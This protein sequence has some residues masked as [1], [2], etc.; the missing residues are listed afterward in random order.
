MKKNLLTVMIALVSFSAIAQNKEMAPALEPVN[1]TQLEGTW[2][3][4]Y[5][6]SQA[7][8]TFSNDGSY[9]I[10]SEA[11]SQMNMSGSY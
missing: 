1:N 8:V 10:W 11:F 4:L 9:A 6:G 7:S 3:G 2:Y 5:A